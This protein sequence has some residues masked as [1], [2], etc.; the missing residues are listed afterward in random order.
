MNFVYASLVMTCIWAGP[1]HRGRL[2]MG[3][4][5]RRMSSPVVPTV[6]KFCVNCQYFIPHGPSVSYGKCRAFPRIDQFTEK[7]VVDHLVTG[8]PSNATLKYYYCSTVRDTERF[9]GR[10]GKMFQE[11]KV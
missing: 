6:P 10:D 11:K 2:L 8:Y 3:R 1:V 7:V 5:K 4:L 9:C